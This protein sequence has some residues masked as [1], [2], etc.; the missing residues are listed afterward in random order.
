VKVVL[1]CGG[2]GL[3]MRGEPD[4]LLPKPMA[5]VGHRPL[6]WHVMR[7]YAHFGHSDFILCLGY[8]GQAIKDYFLHY[9]E[10]ASNDF[11]LDG[12]DGAVTLLSSDLADWRIT[13]V[14][15][16]MNSSIGERLFR[17]REHLAGEEVFLANY[18]DVLTDAHLPDL[19]TRTLDSGATAGL[20]AARPEASFHAVRID[21]SSR[22]RGLM[23]AS[24]VDLWI[25]GGFFVLRSEIFSHLW[26]GIDLVD[27]AFRKL[28][29]EDKLYAYRHEGFWAPSDTLK[30]RLRLEA[31]YH[32][33]SRPWAVWET[34]Q[35]IEHRRGSPDRRQQDRRSPAPAAPPPE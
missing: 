25:N 2:Y 8:G 23:P 4:D 6:I 22:V 32:S 5:R 15:T 9:E 3:R 30:D 20:L 12:R 31:L 16:G 1:F 24:D 10:T 7:Y 14:D 19:I 33:G 21:D 34:S 11:V 35:R 13:F 28:I 27:G 17:V 18:G 26:Y 29:A